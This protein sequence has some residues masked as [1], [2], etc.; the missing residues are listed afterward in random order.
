MR[1]LVPKLCVPV[2]TVDTKVTIAFLFISVTVVLV[3]RMVNF[4]TVVTL[5]VG[6]A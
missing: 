4:A 2:F 3:V 5:G 6:I 1:I